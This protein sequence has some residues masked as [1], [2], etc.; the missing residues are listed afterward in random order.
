MATCESGE[1]ESCNLANSL[2]E[3]YPLWIRRD[4]TGVHLEGG[5]WGVGL[6]V[7]YWDRS[8][9]REVLENIVEEEG[10]RAFARER[11]P[12]WNEKLFLALGPD[13]LAWCFGEHLM[14]LEA[15]IEVKHLFGPAG[16]P[17]RC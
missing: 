3:M 11:G 10:L 2:R 1:W 15:C 12:H 8:E 14:P 13:T 17:L 7:T 9:Y 16:V 5:I 4:I 6:V